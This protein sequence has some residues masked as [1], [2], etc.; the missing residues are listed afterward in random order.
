MFAAERKTPACKR[1]ED[2]E[3]HVGLDLGHHP[4]NDLALQGPLDDRVEHHVLEDDVRLVVDDPVADL[5][6]PAGQRRR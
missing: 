3:A 5:L 2:T 1:T 4:V 6:E